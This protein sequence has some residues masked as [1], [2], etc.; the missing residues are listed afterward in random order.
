MERAKELKTMGEPKAIYMTISKWL[1]YDETI[2][3]CHL[4]GCSTAYLLEQGCR[5]LELPPMT[6]V[7]YKPR[8]VWD[9][10]HRVHKAGEERE[11]INQ[12]LLIY[13]EAYDGWDYKVTPK[14]VLGKM[15]TI[16]L[17]E[18]ALLYV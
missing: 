18:F 14:R 3:H 9:T 1:T 10:Q 12:V 13:S 15:A 4:K 5:E 11:D 17:T 7:V 16:S 6:I 2:Q 8:L